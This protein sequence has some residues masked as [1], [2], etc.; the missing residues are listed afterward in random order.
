MTINGEYKNS[1][2]FSNPYL[3][4]FQPSRSGAQAR[5][6]TPLTVLDVGDERCYRGARVC[7][8]LSQGSGLA[9]MTVYWVNPEIHS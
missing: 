6:G 2:I 4:S 5:A 3:P 1:N 7:P 8:L 9:G